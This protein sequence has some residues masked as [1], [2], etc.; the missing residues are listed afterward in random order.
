MASKRVPQHPGEE[1]DRNTDLIGKY[2]KIVDR[3]L[4]SSDL[5]DQDK[6]TNH[7]PEIRNRISDRVSAI[8]E[9]GY[10]P[11]SNVSLSC[12]VANTAPSILCI[13]NDESLRH[14][15]EW[16]LKTA[17]FRVTSA[18]GLTE[19]TGHFQ[20]GASDLV[21]IGHSMPKEDKRTLLRLLRTQNRI[22]VLLLRRAGDEQI[23]G[24][25]HYVDASQGPDAIV[26]AVRRALKLPDISL[27]NPG[28]GDAGEG[29]P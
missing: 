11:K 1:P 13:S 21:L 7:S 4:K 9:D 6:E 29:E 16:I 20:S 23:P 28:W 26:S 12:T 14:T 18:L 15:R 17:G 19:A 3:C 2:L 5:K 10:P 24:A 27:P 25:D 22:S 8:V